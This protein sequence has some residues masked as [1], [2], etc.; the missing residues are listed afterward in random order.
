[1]VDVGDKVI[2]LPALGGKRIILP[3]GAGQDMAKFYCDPAHYV[4][5]STGHAYDSHGNVIGSWLVNVVC[6][7]TNDVHIWLG[8]DNYPTFAV[9]GGVTFYC[10]PIKKARRVSLTCRGDHMI[11]IDPYYTYHLNGGFISGWMTGRSIATG[12]PKI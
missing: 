2:T 9:Q 11:R 1:M 5:D 4:I 3:M 6:H 10:N 7:N 8:R 12:L